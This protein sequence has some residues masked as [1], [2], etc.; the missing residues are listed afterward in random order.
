M[1]GH[2]WLNVIQKKGLLDQYTDLGFSNASITAQA[3]GIFE[4]IA[5]FTV[6]IRPVQSIVLSI[7]I[8]KMVSELFYPHYEIFEWIER[9]GS[10]GVLLALWFA[11]RN[12]SR[13][14]FHINKLKLQKNRYQL[15]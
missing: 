6:L 9:G 1:L 10:Y 2:G 15:N 4:I 5:A 3:I 11:V 8:W 13:Q 12:A 14:P 7:L